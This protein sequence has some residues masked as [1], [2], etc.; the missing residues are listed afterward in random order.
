M[1]VHPCNRDWNSWYILRSVVGQQTTFVRN[2][3]IVLGG[4][5]DS[6]PVLKNFYWA[7]PVLNNRGP[8]FVSDPTSNQTQDEHPVRRGQRGLTSYLSR[9]L[10]F[11]KFLDT[12]TNNRFPPLDE[13][14]L[15]TDGTTLPPWSTNVTLGLVYKR[16]FPKTRGYT[17]DE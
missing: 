11:V 8:S 3:I 13:L 7:P 16:S 2:K 10:S 4:L 14:S 5:E 6:I 9:S 17:E 12:V 15:R 1:D